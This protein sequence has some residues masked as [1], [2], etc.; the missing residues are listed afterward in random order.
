MIWDSQYTPRLRPLEAFPLNGEEAASDAKIGLRD[1]SGISEVTLLISPPVLELLALMDGR[2]TCEDICRG[3]R[4]AAGVGVSDETVHGLLNHLEEAKFLEG[5][6]FEDHYQLLVDAYLSQPSR[7]MRD[8]AGLGIVDDSGALFD[9][10]CRAVSVPEVAG[11]IV[12]VVAPHL[13]YPRGAPCYGRSYGTLIGRPAPDL[14]VILGTNHFGRSTSVV[15]TAADFSTPLGTTKCDVGFLSS[16]EARC[17]SLRT[18]ELDHAREHSIELQVAWLQHLFGAS[19]IEIVPFLCPDPC[20]PTGTAPYDGCGVDLG[21][22]S[23]HLGD[24]IREANRDVL[25]V[26]GADLSHVGHAFGDESLLDD[27]FLDSVRQCDTDAL[28]HYAAGDPSGF[29]RSLSVGSNATRVCSAGC[30]YA[31]ATALPDAAPTLLE[32]HQA[33]DQSTQTCVSCCS[34]VFCQD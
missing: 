15:S 10:M 8:A 30:M 26:A 6:A 28:E 12:G 27:S 22:F 9:E 32:Y 18:Y 13:D 31:L 1:V 17:G 16:L 21:A 20:G 33:V 5:P 19:H 14:V 2:R 4:A 3:F 34:V 24:L 29:V 11:R 7:P 23:R 25:V